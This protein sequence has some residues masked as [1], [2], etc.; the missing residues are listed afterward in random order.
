MPLE[1]DIKTYTDGLNSPPNAWG[2][3][4]IEGVPSHAYL[5]CM[6]RAWGQEVVEQ[7][8]NEHYANEKELSK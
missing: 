6:Y 3:H 5:G 2:M 4:I 7:A 1:D 8:L